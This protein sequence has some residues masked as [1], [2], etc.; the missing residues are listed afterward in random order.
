[1]QIARREWLL[2]V[3]ALAVRG[4]ESGAMYGLIAKVMTVPDQRDAF[5]QVLIGGTGKMPGCLSYIIAKDPKDE[6]A[7]WV[8]EVWDSKASHDASLSLPEV[9]K[10]I[11]EGRPMVSGF[12]E[13]FET[14][15]VGG[16]GLP[17]KQA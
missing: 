9:K 17:S 16:Y 11:A 7:V 5:I 3:A 12:A 8:T 2:G 4:E 13:R 15:P 1:M 14:T 6:N 10:S